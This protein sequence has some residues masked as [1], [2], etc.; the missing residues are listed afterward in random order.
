MYSVVYVERRDKVE[1]EENRENACLFQ[2]LA[3]AFV[4]VAEQR[5]RKRSKCR[6]YV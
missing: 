3:V 6:F 2:V 5:G 4:C 1:N